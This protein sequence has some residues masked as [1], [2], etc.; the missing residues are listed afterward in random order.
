MIAGVAVVLFGGLL[1]TSAGTGSDWRAVAGVT[2]TIV[3]LVAVAVLIVADSAARGRSRWGWLAFCVLLSPI[4]IPAF[5]IVAVY[6]RL[7]GRLGIEARWAPAGRWYLLGALATAL[8]AA[9]FALSPVHVTG[10]SVS[11]PGASGS[12]SGAC[13]SALAVGL[14]QGPYGPYAA[15]PPGTPPILTNAQATV[16]GRCSA[17]ADKRLTASGFFLGAALLLALTGQIRNRRRYHQGSPVRA[18]G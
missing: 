1:F 5:I 12:Y 7:R 14:G 3:S 4:G 15:L 11:A 2:V 16:A 18:G 8:V 6:D 9:A 17:A 10:E 13:E